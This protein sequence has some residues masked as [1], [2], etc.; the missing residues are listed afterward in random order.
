MLQEN[1]NLWDA[2]AIIWPSV[3]PSLAEWTSLVLRNAPRK[4]ME[5]TAPRWVIATDACRYGWGY[6]ALDV[7][8]MEAT[9]FGGRWYPDFVQKHQDKLGRSTFTEPHAVLFSLRKLLVG[10]RRIAAASEATKGTERMTILV[11]T[12][13]VATEAGYNRGF[14]SRSYDINECQKALK[15][16]WPGVNFI[17]GYIPG[18]ENPA[19][20]WSRHPGQVAGEERWAEATACLGQY[21]GERLG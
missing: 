20:W 13:N 15:K 21:V 14:S 16:E 17:F 4:V 7:A 12:D 3:W 8:T 19:D 18:P 6:V 1:E 11:L 2:P 10:P 5:S 9:S